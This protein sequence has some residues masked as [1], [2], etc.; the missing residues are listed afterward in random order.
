M[1]MGTGKDAYA[2]FDAC[3]IDQMRKHK[4]DKNFKIENA[5]KICGF[6]KAKTEKK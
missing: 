4:G 3:L 5:R 1:P 6:I 2:N